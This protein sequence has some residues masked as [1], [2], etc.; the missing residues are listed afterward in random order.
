MT[1][2]PD[3]AGTPSGAPAGSR[4][5]RRVSGSLTQRRVAGKRRLRRRRTVA[6]VIAVTLALLAVGTATSVVLAYNNWNDRLRHV[7][8][9][10]QLKDRPEKQEV[11]GPQ[12]PL[13]ILVM[14][15]DTR[16]GAGNNID[17]LTGDGERSDTTILLHLSADREHAYGISIP[18]DTLVDRPTC[19]D[20]G[21][22]AIEGAEGTMWNEAFSVGGAACT[23]QQFEQITGVRIDNYVVIDFRGFKDMVNALDGV[24]VC[25]P[26]DI[27]DPEHDI[28][29]E[30]G[31]REI[32]DDEALSYVRVRYTVGDGTD[33]NRIRR[34]QAFMAAMINKAISAGMLVRPD[35]MLSFLNA[36]TGSIQTDYD[37]VAE[38]ADLGR[39]FQGIGLGNIKFVTTPWVYS[40]TQEGRVEWTDEV[41]DLW[42][43]VMD[44]EPLSPEFAQDAISA[45]D[46]PEGETGSS[47]GEGGTG[48]N[49]GRKNRDQGLSDDA[50]ASAG[51]CT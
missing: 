51:L 44:D 5:A 29:L 33:P 14:G 21:G 41:D 6:K 12:E 35:R 46:D 4:K 43:L 42:Q 8:L 15:S 18:R 23:I 3:A 31:T 19:Y 47:D 28:T 37:N 20:E 24:E 7:D 25:I 10:G 50:R 32:R 30:A 16:E 17:G 36:V 22:N 34:Q 40:T 45:A 26:E 48:S 11:E 27:V 2:T 38:L 1:D 13:N 49:G 39:S 9:A